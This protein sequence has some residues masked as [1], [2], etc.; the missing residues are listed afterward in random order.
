MAVDLAV[1]ARGITK[2]FVSREGL[3]LGA[4]W[5]DAHW[6]V[7]SILKYR[8]E[9]RWKHALNGVD[10]EVRRGEFLGLLDPMA[11]GRPPCCAVSR[12]C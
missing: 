7:S 10:L 3:G 11:L 5:G 1:R 8:Q 2:S 9:K 4:T 12:R 6:I